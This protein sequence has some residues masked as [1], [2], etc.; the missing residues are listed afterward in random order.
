MVYFDCDNDDDDGVQF[1]HTLP[2]KFNATWEYFE[3]QVGWSLMVWILLGI[4]CYIMSKYWNKDEHLWAK[5]YVGTT[6]DKPDDPTFDS[7]FRV[8]QLTGSTT[9]VAC[10]VIKSYEKRYMDTVYGFEVVACLGCIAHLIFAIIKHGFSPDYI[11]G[12]EGFIDAFTLTPVLLQPAPGGMWLTVSY[13]RTYRIKTAFY[14]LCASD[15]MDNY[16]GELAQALV[17]NLVD[18][19]A[20]VC[21]LACTMYIFEGLGDVKYFQD[22]FIP[23]GMGEISFFQLCY[24]S[25][26]TMT[27]VG[28]GDY[29][30]TTVFNRLFFFI[31]S[32]GGVTFFSIVTA[33]L[34]DLSSKLSSGLGKFRPKYPFGSKKNPR[35]H[36]LVL[37]GAVASS[38]KACLEFFLKG[39]CRDDTVPEIVLLADECQP[40]VR[41]LLNEPWAK[42]KSITF[43]KGDATNPTDLKRVRAE[44][45]SMTFILSDFFASEPYSEDYSNVLL[46]AALQSYN[47]VAQYRLMVIEVRHLDI[48]LHVGLN[49]FNCYAIDGIKAA[50]LATALRCPGLTTLV[51]N[52]G[53]PD[54]DGPESYDPVISP[55][56]QEYI[57]GAGL[58]PYGFLPADEFVGKTF[59]DA[60]VAIA[61]RAPV[62]VLAAQIDGSIVLN[63]SDH[64]LTKETVLFAFAGDM[65]VCHPFAKNGDASVQTWLP[66]FS[67]NRQTG[68][69][70]SRN[71][72]MQV[73]N[74]FSEKFS[75]SGDELRNPIEPDDDRRSIAQQKP[76]KRL[77]K[78]GMGL[79]KM[80][81]STAPPKSS[82]RITMAG[83]LYELE[84]HEM[85]NEGAPSED[86][87][88]K[89]GHVVLA[90]IATSAE[91]EAFQG[92]WQQVE[93]ILAN[94]RKFSDT[95]LVVIS[96]H[97]LSEGSPVA[98]HVKRLRGDGDGTDSFFIVEGDPLKPHVLLKAG[99]D[100][101]G[102]VLTLSPSA[103]RGTGLM[104]RN[105]ILAQMVIDKKLNEWKRQDLSPA[106]DWYATSSFRL[107]GKA[108]REPRNKMP[109]LSEGDEA[110]A[111]REPR[112]HHRYAC[113]LVLPKPLIAGVLSMAYYTPGLM[114]LVEALIDPAKKPQ[115]CSTYLMPVP[116]EF[117]GKSYK[118]I[119]MLQLD[120]G[121][122]PLGIR[123][124]DKGP[125]PFVLS[126][127]PSNNEILLS[128][129]DSIYVIG[130]SEWVTEF[131]PEILSA[132]TPQE[133]AKVSR[134]DA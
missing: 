47:P 38:S 71:E 25:M 94:L 96:A 99:L 129:K 104:D 40:E 48:C 36:I 46:A 117:V 95:P 128:E 24:F 62:L 18:F 103:P 81:L 58:E 16:L 92:L 3:I 7:I 23:S 32:V 126:C 29:S 76:K 60:T 57:E 88:S 87:V 54:I 70:A 69:A 4:G 116:K 121:A 97:G 15:V 75:K 34:L 118:E 125:Y 77:V 53:L 115:E 35:G 49:M 1:S 68:S 61:K 80:K 41:E 28:Y 66:Q 91:V 20:C 43:F 30:P 44:E 65:E 59:K 17:K 9:I 113:G 19:I 27:T 74:S 31:A 10:W 82:K 83:G 52:C 132:P 98:S 6:I 120:K 33:E 107:M 133:E 130:D 122:I 93:V 86:L 73:A 67:S 78:P 134:H 2:C 85:S 106:Y 26:T 12:L 109:N 21:C 13:L 56:L 100:T 108:P 37:G 55:W 105:N 45:T 5:R 101:A 123:R 119:A 64:F 72:A 79:R 14:R 51:L 11:I 90:L 84:E 89:G 112:T 127:T 111:K 22:R 110:L 39:L 42:S 102:H 131:M 124:G 114:E 50:T 63:P 8:V